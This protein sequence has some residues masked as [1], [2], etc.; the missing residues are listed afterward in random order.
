MRT[1]WAAQRQKKIETTVYTTSQKRENTG[2]GQAR[3][4]FEADHEAAACSTKDIWV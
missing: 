4:K 2:P 1:V 3:N